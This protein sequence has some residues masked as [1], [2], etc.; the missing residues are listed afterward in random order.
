MDSSVWEMGER[1][2]SEIQTLKISIFLRVKVKTCI[3]F[4]MDDCHAQLS[5]FTVSETLRPFL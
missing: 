3:L 2:L 4:C 1:V 5:D